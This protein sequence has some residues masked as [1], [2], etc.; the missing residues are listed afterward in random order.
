MI[1]INPKYNNAVLP[2]PLAERYAAAD[3]PSLR[4][5][6]FLIINGPSEKETISQ[7]LNIP[8]SLVDEALRFWEACGLTVEAEDPVKSSALT[9]TFRDEDIAVMLQEA[10]LFLGRPIDVKESRR[11]TDTV[12]ENSIS[13]DVMLLVLSYCVSNLPSNTNLINYACRTAI[14]WSGNGVY[15]IGSAEQYVRDL[16]KLDVFS[17]KICDVLDIPKEKL[18]KKNKENIR[19]WMNVYGY[20][21]LFVKEAFIRHGKNSINYI[22]SI[23]TTWYKSGYKSIKDTR[24]SLSNNITAG[25]SSSKRDISL[26]QDVLESDEE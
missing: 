6:L 10:Q 16:E 13:P 19:L 5:A 25:R 22:N 12:T 23:L 17:A 1:Q 24:K 3:G 7:K 15:D 26:L 20:D 9:R 8:V 14:E 4:V 2:S 21:E 11:L 18:T